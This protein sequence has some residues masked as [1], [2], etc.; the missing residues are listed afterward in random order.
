MNPAEG[1]AATTHLTY[2]LICDNI[3]L[4]VASPSATQADPPLAS[5]RTVLSTTDC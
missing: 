4:W 5:I 2:W 3:T 1:E